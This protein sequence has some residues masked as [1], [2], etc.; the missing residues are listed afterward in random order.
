MCDAR[1]LENTLGMKGNGVARRWT[2]A[3]T[4]R[5]TSRQTRRRKKRED[6]QTGNETEDATR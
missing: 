5:R 1:R 4:G 3:A 2:D 6:K